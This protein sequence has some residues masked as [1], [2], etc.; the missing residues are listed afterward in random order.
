VLH[1]AELGFK[2]ISIEP[3]VGDPKETYSIRESDLPELFSQYERLAL[4]MLSLGKESFNFFHFNIDLAGGPCV[5]K[6]IKNCG[7]GAEYLAVTPN[8]DI[9]PCHQLA[10]IKEFLMGS[11]FNGIN[12]EL[13]NYFAK[14]N[15][16]SKPECKSCWAKFYCS[17]GCAAAAI[18]QNK[19]INQPYNIGCS[20]MKKRMECAV[21]LLCCR[22]E[23]A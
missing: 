2:N 11:I 20:L 14:A 15:I 16:Y 21:Y 1:L 12:L 22:A 3:V 5:I 6:R 4:E 10:G 13:G 9:Y 19:D 8:G 18:T 7:A 23:S 17:G